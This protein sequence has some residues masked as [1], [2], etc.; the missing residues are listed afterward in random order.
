L[1]V[2]VLPRFGGN[3]LIF[4]AFVAISIGTRRQE[5]KKV[6]RDD[7]LYSLD[8]WLILLGAVFSILWVHFGRRLFSVGRY[9]RL[10]TWRFSSF[11]L[12]SLFSLCQPDNVGKSTM[13]SSIGFAPKDLGS[14]FQ[15]V[16]VYGKQKKF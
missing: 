10:Y 1:G 9:P 11:S 4:S 13:D 15:R 8:R 7:A 12:S 2:L 3:H 16:F 5:K 6:H 14:M